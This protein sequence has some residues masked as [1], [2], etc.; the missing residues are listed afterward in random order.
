MSRFLSFYHV[1]TQIR[2]IPAIDTSYPLNLVHFKHFSE[3]YY[4]LHRPQNNELLEYSR[5]LPTNIILCIK[6]TWMNQCGLMGF[7]IG[8]VIRNIMFMALF[9]VVGSFIFVT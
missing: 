7:Q 9:L 4:L 3:I 8:L 5:H 6:L 1:Y 2:N